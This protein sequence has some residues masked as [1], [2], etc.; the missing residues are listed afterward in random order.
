[1]ADKVENHPAKV[2]L[3]G[4]VADIL[5]EREIVLNI[6]TADG[7]LPGMR[8]AI[9]DETDYEVKDPK[10]GE[11]LGKLPPREKVRVEIVELAE[12]LS[13]ARTYQTR[14]KN[15]GGTGPDFGALTRRSLEP[16][17]YVEEPVTFRVSGGNTYFKKISPDESIVKIGDSV[18][19]VD[20]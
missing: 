14:Q 8:F 16:A 3:R 2:M 9:L 4:V 6:G 18:R 19:Q 1:M 7:V 20:R 15:I 17:Y 11:I 13:V 5:N 10:T 12:R